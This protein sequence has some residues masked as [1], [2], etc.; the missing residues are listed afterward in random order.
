[1]QKVF[2]I[3]TGDRYPNGDA[4][5]IRT[6]SFAKILQC[7]GYVPVVI[8]MGEMTDFKERQYEGISYYSLRYSL[9]NFI[10]KV[11]GRLLYCHNAK[12]II[13][14]Y[15]K[16]ELSGIMYVSG[17]K[18]VFFWIKKFADQ[19]RI[20]LYHDC[21]EW[22][23]PSEFS[24]GEKNS[25]YRFTDQL[26]KEYIDQSFGVIAIS[27]YLEEHFK[28]RKIKTIRVPVIM[29]VEHIQCKKNTN[30]EYVKI[31]YAG[32]M[33]GKDKINYFIKALEQLSTKELEKLRLYII[34]STLENYE[35]DFGK[36]PDYIKERSIIF[37]GRISRTEVLEHLQSTD[38]T[39][40]LRPEQE[41]YAKA[42]FPTKVVESLASGTPV[43]CNYTSDLSLY[44][45]NMKDSIEVESY[46]VEACVKALKCALQTTQEE[47][48]VMQSNARKTAEDHFDWRL[49]SYQMEHFWK[50]DM[51]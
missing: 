3:I 16:A 33:G 32:A 20:P 8:G 23:S 43:I 1:M 13:K 22:F 47:R 26:N 14:Q 50:A 17:G 4:G 15:P 30:K 44:L 18:K 38:F 5:A 42:G 45:R 27:S 37:T 6:H 36:I 9:D 41:R 51:N 10:L 29:D 25:M 11:L 49:Y 19:N 12:R 7:T 28:K 40:L 21:V 46:S 31:A 24:N 48:E 39:I 2:L 35:K 34:G